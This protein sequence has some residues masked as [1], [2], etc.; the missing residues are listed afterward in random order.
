MKTRDESLGA[1]RDSATPSL[2][3]PKRDT[4]APAYETAARRAECCSVDHARRFV[5]RAGLGL[6]A[7]SVLD[8][9]GGAPAGGATA[10]AE[11]MNVG[12]LGTGQYPARAKRVIMLHMLGAISHVDTFDY[13]PMLEKMTGQEIPPSVRESAAA[14]DDVRRAVGVSDRRP[15][16][17]VQAPRRERRVGQRP[18]AVYRQGRG[19]ALLRQDAAH[20]AR[21]PRSRVEVPAHGLPARGTAVRG[22]LGQLCARLRQPRLA[23]LRRDE[24]GRVT[25]RAA[26]RGDLGPGLPALASPGRR[27]SRGERSGAVRQ[28]PCP[29]SIAPTGARCSTRS[30][31]SRAS[32]TSESH[33]P[34]ILSRVS[35]YEMAYRMQASVP[36]VADISDEP[37]YVLAMYGPGREEARHVRAQLPDRAAA[38]RA[39]RE[40]SDAVRDGLGPAPRDQAAAAGA[41][42]GDRSAVRGPRDGLEAARPARRH[43]RDVR[44]R[45][46]PHAVRAGPDRQSARGPRPPRRVLH[47]VA[48]GRRSQG[49]PDAT[50]RPTI[51]A[52]TSCAIRSTSTT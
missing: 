34:E 17:A 14:V 7:L 25:G 47:L 46:R 28:Q 49:R 44:Q 2:T 11:T 10:A 31:S 38:R 39:R 16:R 15:A 41:L 43:A 22:R 18:P 19:R 48:R 5:L 29:A 4:T 33:D 13:K 20:R 26:G 21:E 9:L 32:S 36:E 30:A 12:V 42:P 45:V 52:T 3:D 23:E 6:G 51:S 1:E 24:L 27:V 50:A 37:E 35:Q 40:V 8:M